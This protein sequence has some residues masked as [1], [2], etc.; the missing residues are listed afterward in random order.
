MR[1]IKSYKLF[2]SELLLDNEHFIELKEI[3]QSKIFDEFDI[4]GEVDFTSFDEF[5]V[6]PYH[7]FW[8]YVIT[9]SLGKWTCNSDTTGK[10][11]SI[12]IFNVNSEELDNI[13]SILNGLVGQVEESIGFTLK[14]SIEK[15][16]GDLYDYTIKLN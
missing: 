7:K 8:T 11:N 10:I 12:A 6:Y 3:L 14:Y 1:K 5:N 9:G 4:I 15:Y 2:E 16:D 13:N